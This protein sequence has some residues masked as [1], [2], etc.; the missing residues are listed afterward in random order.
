MTPCRVLI[1]EDEIIIA[2]DIETKLLSYGHT[3]IC[4][5]S[6]GEKAVQRALTDRPDLITMDIVLKGDMDGIEAARQINSS[7]NIPIIFLTSYSDQGIIDKIKHF[8]GTYSYILKPFKERELYIAIETI[9]NRHYSDR[10]KTKK[11]RVLL[12]DGDRSSRIEIKSILEDDYEVIEAVT[13]EIGILVAEKETP[14]IILLEVTL[15]VMDGYTVCHSLKHKKATR[16]IPV[17]FVSTNVDQREKVVGLEIGGTDFISKPIN[18]YELLAR[19]EKHIKTHIYARQLE[20]Q[21][22]AR[23]QQ[24]I[25]ADRLATL[26]VFAAGLTHEINNPNTFI[27]G[28]IQTLRNFWQLAKP[29]LVRHSNETPAITDYLN[30]IDGILEGIQEGSRRISVIVNSSKGH[31]K[32]LSDVKDINTLSYIINEALV[33]LKHRIKDGISVKIDVPFSIRLVCNKQKLSQVFVNLIGNA[34]DALGNNNASGEINVKAVEDT[35]RILIKINDNGTGI[36]QENL[37]KIFDPFFTTK[38][39]KDGTG[40]GLYIVKEIIDEHSG[41]VFVSKTGITGTE[42]TIILPKKELS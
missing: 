25:H 31:A 19:I 22:H 29:I 28:N 30:E 12:I 32:V 1:V 21:I 42:F 20:E 37:L 6:T 33:L 36:S 3:V 38:G 4:Q 35:D 39:T 40:L 9:L 41:V 17:I 14:D 27:S 24:L 11:Q 10:K 15:P 18:K 23:T 8:G 16:R 7:L 13:G 5:E 26:G 34:I 2:K